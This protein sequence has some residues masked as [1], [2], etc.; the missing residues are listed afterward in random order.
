[1][2]VTDFKTINPCYIL[3]FEAL[4]DKS[5]HHMAGVIK[6]KFREVFIMSYN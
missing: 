6:N 4:R 3:C 1:M 5:L 2:V